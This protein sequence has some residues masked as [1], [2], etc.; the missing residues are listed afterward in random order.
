MLERLLWLAMGQGGVGG[1]ETQVA[2]FGLQQA[3]DRQC[4]IQVC[5]GRLDFA[6]TIEGIAAQDP[7]R[8]FAIVLG[9]CA[10]CGL[11]GPGIIPG[12]EQGTDQQL[13]IGADFRCP[14]HGFP[15]LVHGQ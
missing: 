8:D 6:L 11:F 9:Q 7:R 2:D 13:L 3:I 1:E 14:G 5:L 10:R 4:L 15:G 12:G